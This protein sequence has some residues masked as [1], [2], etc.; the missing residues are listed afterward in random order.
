ME[1][2]LKSQ[3]ID[4]FHKANLSYWIQEKDLFEDDPSQNLYSRQPWLLW[5]K[6]RLCRLLIDAQS[7][8]L[9]HDQEKSKIIINNIFE[10]LSSWNVL[11]ITNHATFA[12]Y[13]I[14]I[15]LFTKEAENRN[16]ES[17]QDRIYTIL[18]PLLL[19][20][21]PQ[22]NII[23]SF[24]NCLKTIPQSLL[25]S[26]NIDKD[27]EWYLW[28]I[29]KGFLIQIKK[30]IKAK[31]N[32]FIISPTWTRDLVI[33]NSINGEAE[34]ICFENDWWIYTSIRL[35]QLIANQWVDIVFAGINDAWLKNPIHVHEKNNKWTYSN[36]YVDFEY[37]TSKD[38]QW[39]IDNWIVMD[40]LAS[41]IYD[42]NWLN[43]WST[44]ASDK[45]KLAKKNQNQ[46]QDTNNNSYFNT[47]RRKTIR[48]L[49][50]LLY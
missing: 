13:P 20:N 48:K 8:T 40:T 19:T 18:W 47:L 9:F 2:K 30:L 41:L 49:F 22:R 27:F 34:K 6:S 21:K 29:T 14:L 5:I 17:F 42:N 37:F 7:Q 1:N 35:L 46:I 44:M 45:L 11:I 33:R 28:K 24:S 26:E 38:F 15:D 32:I 31:W 23:L 10:K 12:W 4:Y 3:Y 36:I 25:K 50:S 43:I 16:I 39:L